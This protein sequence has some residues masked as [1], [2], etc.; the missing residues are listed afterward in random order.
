MLTVGKRLAP[1][2]TRLHLTS[3]L[4]DTSSRT[5]PATFPK[6]VRFADSQ[7]EALPVVPVKSSGFFLGLT[8]CVTVETHKCHAF[9]DSG[10]AVNLIKAP[11]FQAIS[12]LAKY[13]IPSAP[14]DINV[15]GISGNL[16]TPHCKVIL[17]LSLSP[18][19][20]AVCGE[21]YVVDNASFS[22]DLLIGYHTM[23]DANLSL[24]PASHQIAQNG[25]LISATPPPGS[26][27]P[28]IVS[29]ATPTADLASP[30]STPVLVEPLTVTLPSSSPSSSPDSAHSPSDMLRSTPTPPPPVTLA[31]T[32]SRAE[33]THAVL[34][35]PAVVT[36]GDLCL[37][38]V[39]VKDVTP[40]TDIIC[41]PES[42][43][44]NG[45]AFESVLATIGEDGSCQ[46]AIQNL[47]NSPL[48][49]KAGVALGD[50]I[51][52]PV[53]VTP[54]DSAPC[55]AIL[56]SEPSAE[57]SPILDHH[58][59][60]VDFP[61]E[62]HELL[63]LLNHFRQCVSLP[64]EALGHTD[65]I[66]HAIHLIP[67]ATP[68][69]VPAYRVPVSRR[70]KV[71]DAVRDML[72]KDVIEPA[73]SPFNAPLLLVPKA[74]GEWRVV[75]DFR[76]LNSLTVPD[77]HPMPVLTDLLQSLGDSN[78]VFSTIDLQSGFFQ[79]ELEERSRPYTAFTTS[80]GQY[81]FKR[82]A[83][84]LRNSPL[85]FTRLMNS[86]LAGLMGNSVFC[87]LDDVIIASKTIQ[88][89][90]DTLSQVLSRFAQAGLKLKLSKCSFLKRQISFL[91]HRVDRE[92]IHTLD[93]KISAVCKFP[94]PTNVDQI[95]SFIGLAGFYRQFIKGF[96]QIAQPLS[97]LLKKNVPFTWSDDQE[98]AFLTLKHALCNAPVL[99]FPDFERDFTLCTDASATGLGAVLMQPDKHGKMRAI[100]YASRL[101]NKAELNYAVT[102]KEALAVVWALR[103]FRDL[104][105]GFRIHVFTDHYAVTEL[106]NG[107][108]LTGKFARWQ[109][110][111]QE[112]N[113]SFSYLPGK[114]NTVADALSRITAP[115][116]LLTDT[117][118]LPTLEEIKTHQRADSFCS[119]L[120]YFLESGDAS[121]L[122]KMHMSP[123]AFTLK[124]DV[125]FKS[126]NIPSE[127]ESLHSVSQLVIPSSLIEVILYHVHDS[128]LAGHP[129]KDRCFRQA[130]KA[131]F[132]PTMRK[133]ITRHCLLC[134]SCAQHRPSIHFESKNLAYPIPHAP[135]DSISVDILKLPLTENGYQY[136]LVCV[137]SFSRFTILVPL[138][139]KS[140]RSVSQAII[141][142]VIC[143]YTSPRVLLSDNG[144]EFNNSILKEICD[145]FQIKKCNIIAHSPQA[146]GKVERANR[147]ILDILRH[148]TVSS[149]TWDTWISLVACSLNS[150][151][152]SASNE[153]PHFILYGTDKRL[154]YEF[155]LSQ[156][157]PLYNLDDY[158][159]ARLADFQ[160]IHQSVHARLTTS[161]HEMLRKQHQRAVPHEINV[162]DS[163][164][165]RS[166]DRHSK[167]DPLFDGPYRVTASLHGHKFRI[168]NL[169]SWKEQDVHMDHLKR[170]D[171]G[172]D[173]DS[174]TP[175]QPHT[176]AISPPSPP[177][178]LFPSAPPL[179]P[180]PQQFPPAP[181]PASDP[182]YRHKLRSHSALSFTFPSPFHTFSS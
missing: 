108:S 164:F 43:R 60:D 8:A 129:G 26:H 157:R 171:R 127:D 162:G 12:R 143:T 158:V 75:V 136:L 56:P 106:F 159:R 151:I 95:R 40:G 163:V 53:P 50:V 58:V 62:Q 25:T 5:G 167:L 18:E 65:V 152:H 138:K 90:L 51:P 69:Y 165:L 66:R 6:R 38:R 137:D 76:K 142:E 80:R 131:Y 16:I 54:L 177:T 154:P 30:P 79:V 132:W 113:P 170:V 72:E 37:V 98:K 128:P 63:A 124:D 28:P 179:F 78:E 119:K 81:M 31:E 59:G 46:V 133:D 174:P 3:I 87:Y 122:P 103:H 180:L 83:M 125:L 135:W 146:N 130:Q 49:L 86:V 21:F 71:D 15:C 77:R 39:S 52:Y 109:L 17:K 149:S 139:D 61:E 99:A 117:Q 173:D 168:L 147:R 82:M 7:P 114:C 19:E 134:H 11:T 148:I 175:L 101:L 47:T 48:S 23:V 107:H 33:P 64:G 29:T 161:Q 57:P 10:A 2:Q 24:F 110:T 140:A 144:T 153:S 120:I 150:A 111:V 44:V 96:S 22:A 178:A 4:K 70:S 176:S 115:V 1:T 169:K 155:L 100:A 34:T 123:L 181:A 67:D 94:T 89:H 68:A 84:G 85:T 126:A 97:A 160:R 42:S 118:S 105:L 20:P 27:Y 35:A 104:I 45:V 156:P 36:Q 74:N 55:H 32:L 14:T 182:P 13:E 172:F 141:N 73:A 116:S 9:L 91:G 166:H 121:N 102:H 145:V 93:D 88:E 41:I 112:F 92:G